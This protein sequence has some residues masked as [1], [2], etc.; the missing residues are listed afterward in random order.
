[1]F[2]AH[3]VLQGSCS[4]GGLASTVVGMPW[5]V[6]KFYAQTCL[7]VITHKYRRIWLVLN[8]MVGCLACATC[9]V[10]FLLSSPNLRGWETY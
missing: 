5:R 3:P 8:M 9:D 2:R 10:V 6:L 1:M 4:K 7:S